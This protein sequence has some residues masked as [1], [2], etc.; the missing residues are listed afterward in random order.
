MLKEE[1]QMRTNGKRKVLML[2][3]VLLTLI[4]A[5]CNQGNADSDDQT[6]ASDVAS[7]ETLEDTSE[8]SVEDSEDK[9][10]EESVSESGTDEATVDDN[11]NKTS[12]ETNESSDERN[13]DDVD[14]TEDAAGIY[15]GEGYGFVSEILVD[16]ELDGDEIIDIKVV[17]GNDTPFISEKAYEQ[18]TEKIVANQTVNVDNVSGATWTS[19]GVKGA[20][21]DALEKAGKADSFKDSMKA[22][23][24][25]AAEQEYDVVVV[26]G[27]ASGLT[28]SIG[29]VTDDELG[30]TRS[31]LKVLVLEQLAYTGGSIRVSD[32]VMA[33]YNNTPYNEVTNTGVDDESII[34]Y[35]KAIDADGILTEELLRRVLGNIPNTYNGLLDQGVYLPV[36]NAKPNHIHSN[37]EN[38][39]TD[40]YWS[41]RNPYT[42]EGSYRAD[43]HDGLHFGSYGGSPWFAQSLE[44]IAKNRGVEVRTNAKVTELLIEGDRV[45]GVRV[46]DKN[47]NTTYEVKAKSVVVATGP[48]GHDAA[49]MERF[50]EGIILEAKHYGSAGNI[51]MGQVWAEDDLGAQ[52]LDRQQDF[53][54][55]GFDQRMGFY[56]KSTGLIQDAPSIWVNL[57]GERFTDESTFRKANDPEG[58]RGVIQQTDGMIYGIIDSSSEYVDL[59]Q[60]VIDHGVGIK[61]DSIEE[62]AEKTGIPYD[63]LQETINNYNEVFESGEDDTDFGT[64]NDKMVPIETGPFYA[65]PVHAL[66]NCTYISVVVNDDMQP[67]NAEGEVAK[68]GVYYSG[69][70]IAGNYVFMDGGFSHATALSSGSLVANIIRAQLIEDG[71]TVNTTKDWDGFGEE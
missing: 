46:E 19:V 2:L 4:F 12:E 53:W 11:E 50:A 22:E 8:E 36:E 29:L 60:P 69:S 65:Y 62:L 61:A 42:G 66:N 27:G 20:V 67:V 6:E 38:G 39:M 55:L 3:L 33:A 59:M 15:R 23:F 44:N 70:I 25:Q 48:I 64:V 63:K 58:Y 17:E 24:S 56:G 5:A 43:E 32:G 34:E 31:G 71:V 35:T 28:A 10:D 54:H 41:I 49:I 18:L 16:V 1:V 21:S 14:D 9:K 26:G 37:P 7:S 51:G 45:I 30:M 47:D 68:E 57:E 40:A 13:E 52:I